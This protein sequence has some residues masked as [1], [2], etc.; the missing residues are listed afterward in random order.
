CP[1]N[2][3]PVQADSALSPALRLTRRTFLQQALIATAG[4]IAVPHLLSSSVRAADP[5]VAPADR[6][7]LALIGKG[8]MGSVHL[9]FLSF[10]DDVELLAVCDVDQRR[11]EQCAAQVNEALSDKEPL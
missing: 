6:I 11:A 3:P 9:R 10:R 5:A 2:I 4:T 1:M 8:S 7:R